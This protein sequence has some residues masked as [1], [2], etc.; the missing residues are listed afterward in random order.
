MVALQ[1]SPCIEQPRNFVDPLLAGAQP[2]SKENKI[3]A[4]RLTRLLRHGKPCNPGLRE[5]GFVRVKSIQSL[6]GRGFEALSFDIA[7][8]IVIADNKMR[9]SLRRECIEESVDNSSFVEAE[10]SYEW[11]IRANQ[12]YT[13]KGLDPEKLLTRVSDP[14]LIPVV[15]HGTYYDPWPQIRANGLSRMK[16][17]HIHFARGLPNSG[18]AAQL[19]EESSTGGSGGGGSSEWGIGGVMSGMRSNV[20]LLVYVDAAIAMQSG[21]IFY[22]SDNDVILTPGIGPEGVVPPSCFKE[23]VDT[24][25]GKVIFRYGVDIA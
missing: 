4:R 13:I 22:I 23:V 19:A 14:A 18:A 10:K 16:R 7:R 21:V 12:G 3:L 24:K 9:F 11:W 6:S 20:Q 17:N 8:D 5:D 1:S 2:L 25:T 15:I